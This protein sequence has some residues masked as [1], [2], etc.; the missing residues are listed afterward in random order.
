MIT[1]QMWRLVKESLYKHYPVTFIL[2]N[3]TFNIPS[4][5]IKSELVL[6]VSMGSP[7][8]SFTRD[9]KLPSI[10]SPLWDPQTVFHTLNMVT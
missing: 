1:F 4:F 5:K 6:I 3:L 9:H 8:A 10:Q 2:L 7:T